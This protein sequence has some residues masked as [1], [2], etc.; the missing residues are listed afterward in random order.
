MM[1]STAFS[2]ENTAKGSRPNVSLPYP[3]RKKDRCKKVHRSFALFAYRIQMNVARD[4]LRDAVLHHS[5]G[6]FGDTLEV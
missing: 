6:N 2:R 3:T 1:G 5:V 4:A